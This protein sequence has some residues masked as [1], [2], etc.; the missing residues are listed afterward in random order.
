MLA[1][2][3]AKLFG[4]SSD[5]DKVW[6]RHGGVRGPEPARAGRDYKQPERRTNKGVLFTVKQFYGGIGQVQSINFP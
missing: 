2:G 1:S 5:I 6:S 3:A 4:R